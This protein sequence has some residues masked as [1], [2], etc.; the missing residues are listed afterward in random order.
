M[1]TFKNSLYNNRE[2][3]SISTIKVLLKDKYVKYMIL[4]FLFVHPPNECKGSLTL[5]RDLSQGVDNSGCEC[6][7]LSH[8][9]DSVNRS[10]EVHFQ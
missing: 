9:V 6:I 2:S 7:K 10:E 8:H 3:P 5:I 4:G 1:I